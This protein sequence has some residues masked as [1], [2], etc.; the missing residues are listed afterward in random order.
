MNCDLVAAHDSEVLVRRSTSH[1]FSSSLKRR[2][3]SEWGLLRLAE[4]SFLRASFERS[5]PGYLFMNSD[6]V[7]AHDLD[8]RLR[9]SRSHSRCSGVYSLPLCSVTGF[10]IRGR[11]V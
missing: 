9:R 8:L 2:S 6:L 5:G 10:C 7:S 11:H 3:I 4:M 1:A